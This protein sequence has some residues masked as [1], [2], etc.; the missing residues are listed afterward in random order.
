MARARETVE[1]ALRKHVPRGRGIL[2]A[3]SGGRDSVCLLRACAEMTGELQIRLEAAHLDHSLREESPEDAEFVRDL[4]GSLDV[5]FH[6]KREEKPDAGVNIESW[7]RERRYAFFSDVL[8]SAGLDFVLTAHTAND[9]AETLLMRM[10][11]NKEMRTIARTDPRRRCIRPLLTV[12]RDMIDEWNRE[13]GVAFIDDATNE[14]ASFLRNRVRHRLIPFLREEFDP[15]IVEVLCLRAL[16]LDEDESA[17]SRM[18]EEA[19]RSLEGLPFESAEWIR[20]FRRAAALQPSAVQWRM[21]EQI[22]LP[23][24]GY[25]PGR[26]QAKEALDVLTGK[27]VGME[28][29]GGKSLRRS[30]G[31]VKLE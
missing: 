21:I 20:E 17:L 16:S 1:G 4:C 26:S 27:R 31:R 7:G 8:D 30:R 23:V 18:A 15:R 3:V 6:L 22:L 12:P 9:V 19:S 24:T 11:A 14:D 10:V 28:F 25:K 13:H 29:S 2:V 5:A